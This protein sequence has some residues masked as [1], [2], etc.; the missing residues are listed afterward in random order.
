MTM[1]LRG[2]RALVVGLMNK[3]SLAASITQ[4]FLS[5]GA[6]VVV[7]SKDPL[8]AR[9]VDACGFVHGPESSLQVHAC[10]VQQE[11]SIT[12]LMQR[13]SET[14]DGELDIL[15][16]SIAFAP[17]ETFASGGTLAV[18]ADAWRQAM[19]VSAYSLIA[20]TR[21]A[22]PLLSAGNS[23]ELADGIPATRDRSVLALSYAG[24]SKVLV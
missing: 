14:F 21:A 8:T 13:C 9:Q 22:H 17:R 18:S 12:E 5:Q 6:S 19:D 7:A 3:H 15:V 2:K 16:H 4:S 11:E 23:D 24:A 1:M 10:D 20:L